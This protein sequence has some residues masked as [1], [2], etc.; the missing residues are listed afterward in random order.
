[1]IKHEE[2]KPGRGRVV[3]ECPLHHGSGLLRISGE[4][5]EFVNEELGLEECGTGAAVAI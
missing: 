5:F 2:D 1:M 4:S 3:E